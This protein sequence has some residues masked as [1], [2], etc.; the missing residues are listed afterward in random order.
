MEEE[1]TV[2]EIMRRKQVIDEKVAGATIEMI[3]R[4]RT[5]PVAQSIALRLYYLNNSIVEFIKLISSFKLGKTSHKAPLLLAKRTNHF[6]TTYNSIIDDVEKNLRRKDAYVSSL[7]KVEELKEPIN[8][9]ILDTFF[10]LMTNIE[11]IMSYLIR[12]TKPK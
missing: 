12:W 4:M 2:N 1:S 6:I 5:Q 8:E 3:E 10:T 7:N 11:Q 9:E